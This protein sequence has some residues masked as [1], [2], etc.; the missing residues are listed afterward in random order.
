[1]ALERLDDDNFDELG[2][3]KK[4]KRD[5]TDWQVFQRIFSFVWNGSDK[6]RVYG[7]LAISI[8]FA[9]VQFVNPW[10]IKIIVSNGLD[11]GLPGGTYNLPLVTQYA[12][13]LAILLCGSIFLWFG[14]GYLGQNLANKSMYQLRQ[15][16]FHN[17]Q[18]L[19]F[20]Y[21]N[22]KGR[23]SGKSFSYITNDVET[24]QDSLM[25]DY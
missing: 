8:I 23:S 18:Q 4:I 21:Y 10:I 12:T 17:L 2:R 25:Q 9:V 20:D 24:I 13:Y 19:S 22:E 3:P 6:K 5:I 16:L 11:N 1:M 15:D 14:Q 7:L